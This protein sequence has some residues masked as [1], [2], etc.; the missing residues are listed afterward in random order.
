MH[1]LLIVLV[2]IRFTEPVGVANAHKTKY[3]IRWTVSIN[4]IKFF[5]LI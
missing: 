4:D 1:N 2:G 3:D 5:K